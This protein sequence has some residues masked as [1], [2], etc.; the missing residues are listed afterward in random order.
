[1]QLSRLSF[2]KQP[3]SSLQGSF[4]D[5]IASDNDATWWPFIDM[6]LL[7]LQLLSAISNTFSCMF[8]YVHGF[9]FC[10]FSLLKT[11]IL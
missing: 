4:L 11:L 3:E 1:M 10:L 5:W 6:Q 2:V 8:F 7:L 9:L